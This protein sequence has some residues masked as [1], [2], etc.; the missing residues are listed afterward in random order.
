MNEADFAL[1]R[2]LQEIGSIPLLTPEEEVALARRIQTGD[3]VARE[4]MIQANLRL[5]VAIAQ[6]YANLGLPMLDLISEGNIGLMRAV[7]RF[8]PKKGAKLSTYASWWIKQA[9]KR[10]LANQSKTIRLPTQ[11]VEKIGQ[12]R[13]ISAQVSS[14]LGHE[15]TDEE[16]GEELGISSQKVAR[17]KSV[18]LRPQSLNAFVDDDDTTEFGENVPDE[19]AQTPFELFREKDFSDQVYRL[20]ETLNQRETTIITERFGLNGT[21]AKPLE[22]VAQLI[23]VT[24]ERVR[25]LELAALAKLRR[26]F[27]KHLDPVE[28]EA[29]AAA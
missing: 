2:Y 29:F 10:A 7:D 8:D 3:S 13:R 4:W 21:A 27:S 17:L 9:I 6:D 12:M 1:N 11:V 5:V 22:Q 26:A 18:G 25:K 20:L 14:D 24:H 23:G 15:A 16:L 19:Q 28:P